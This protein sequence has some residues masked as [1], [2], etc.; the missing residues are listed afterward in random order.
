[1]PSAIVLLHVA[2]SGVALLSVP[3]EIGVIGLIKFL[4]KTLVYRD[5]L[6]ELP[7]VSWSRYMR[8]LLSG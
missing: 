6:D 8:Q 5:S 4:L 1:M 3:I 7:A 2:P